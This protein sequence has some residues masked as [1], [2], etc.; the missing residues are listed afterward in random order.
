MAQS[1]IIKTVSLL[2]LSLSVQG[3]ELF[4]EPTNLEEKIN[5]SGFIITEVQDSTGQQIF[6]NGNTPTL[7]FEKGLSK[8]LTHFVNENFNFKS[9]DP[10]VIM[11][12]KNIVFTKNKIYNSVK[13][14][15]KLQV[16]FVS[17]GKNIYGFESVNTLQSSSENNE[18]YNRLI[19][20]GL[21]YQIDQFNTYFSKKL[22]SNLNKTLN[23]SVQYLTELKSKDYIY[24]HQRPLLRM[25]DFE[26]TPNTT[27]HKKVAATRSGLLLK[28]E[29]SEVGHEIN[30]VIKI[31]AAFDKSMSWMNR[32][33]NP[34]Y[35]LNHEQFHFNISGYMACRLKDSL[36]NTK[37]RPDDFKIQ[38]NDV[39][40]YWLKQEK[41]MQKDYDA[42][43]RNGI[44]TDKQRIWQ[45]K[46][47]KFGEEFCHQ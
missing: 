38:V 1:R 22:K 41:E 4:I 5:Y 9:P 40:A 26:G 34:A 21:A 3:Q 33:S 23:F 25:E 13:Y 19:A 35:T 15:L 47:I 29:T 6:G 27:A 44:L 8:T 39:F 24:F 18:Y 45:E 46:I 36:E 16:N 31:S 14:T 37:L 2:L 20:Q 28:I 11:K 7:V 30:L 43:T 17:D 42:E 32:P 12:V 10:P